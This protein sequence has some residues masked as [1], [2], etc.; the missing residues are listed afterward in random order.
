MRGNLQLN[1]HYIPSKDNPSDCPSLALS[2]LDCTLAPATWHK[3]QQAFGP[4]TVDLMALTANVMPDQSG[5]PLKFFSPFPTVQAAGAIV[6][7]QTIM[8][9][10]VYVFPPFVLV[11]PLLKFLQTQSCS[12][13]IVVPDLTPRQ[14]WWPLSQGHCSAAFLLGKKAFLVFCSFLT[15]VFLVLEPVHYNGTCGS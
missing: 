4:D 3:I 8:S 1:L 14:Y 12:F 6:F 11:G 15:E 9:E 13:S 7:S 5:N 10:N 2:D